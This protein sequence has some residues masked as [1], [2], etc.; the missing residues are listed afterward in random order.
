MERGN[1]DIETNEPAALLEWVTKD[2]L[3][4]IR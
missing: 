3:I 1:R 2:G 4:M